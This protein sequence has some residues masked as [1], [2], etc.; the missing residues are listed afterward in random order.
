[1]SDAAPRLASTV[2][3]VRDGEQGLE[4]FMERRHIKSDFVGGAYVFPGGAVDPEDRIPEQLCRGLDEPSASARLGLD[5]GGLAYH[6]AAIRE[7][8]EE[9]G[10]LLAYDASGSIL[11]FGDGT[12]REARFRAHRDALNA[13]T[14]SLIEIAEQERLV[15]ATDLV[16]YWA[17]WITPEGQP[18]RYDTR[19]FIAHAPENQTAAHDDWELTHSAWVTPRLA[20]EKALRREWMIIFPTVVNLAQLERFASVEHVLA[21]ARG[22]HPRPMMVPRVRDGDA[23][24]L[25]GD[26]GYEEA[27]RDTSGLDPELWFRQLERA[28][29]RS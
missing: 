8:F 6:V 23:I 22:D 13:G 27:R 15:L 5:H 10:V 19:F 4:V 21:H 28:L 1:M 12:E 20:I 16:A 26:E 11:D 29:A 25:P 3:L 7:C 17:H 9:A 14:R 18:R 24:V 2:L